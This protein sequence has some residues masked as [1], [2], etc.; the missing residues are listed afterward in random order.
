MAEKILYL[1]REVGI[2]EELISLLFLGVFLPLP[3]AVQANNKLLVCYQITDDL[4]WNLRL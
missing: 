2:T 3:V 1:L 4:F